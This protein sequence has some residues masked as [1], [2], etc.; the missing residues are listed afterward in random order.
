MPRKNRTRVQRK[1]VSVDSLT[2]FGRWARGQPR[3]VLSKAVLATG[4]AY[5]TVLTAKTRRVTRD[6]A[7]LLSGFTRGEVSIA[8]LERPQPRNRRAA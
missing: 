5:T 8:E 6:V 4:L 2:A 7:E 1:L 3:G